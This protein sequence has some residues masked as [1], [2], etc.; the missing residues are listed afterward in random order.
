M[1]L[2]MKYSSRTSH[3]LI[4]L[5]NGT[6]RTLMNLPLANGR[7]I[8]Q[9]ETPIDEW[10]VLTYGRDQLKWSISLSTIPQLSRRYVFTKF[11]RILKAQRFS[12]RDKTQP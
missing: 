5:A 11:L 2:L 12:T 6:S 7:Y 9:W 1:P 3:T 4:S 8:H 10:L